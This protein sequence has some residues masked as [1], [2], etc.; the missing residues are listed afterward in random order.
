M[1]K[2]FTQ[3]HSES[4]EVLKKEFGLT[5]VMQAPRLEKVVINSGVGKLKDKKKNEYIAS[6]LAIITGQKAVPRMAKKSIATFKLREGELVGLQV[7]L[8]GPRMHRF[9]D[10]LVNIALPRMKDFRGIP[11]TFDEMGNYTLGIRE[12]NIFP[13]TAEDDLK[14]VFGFAITVVTTSPDAAASKRLL[15]HLNFPF[16]K[17]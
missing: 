2:T 14:D 8:R 12:H 9:L 17:G 13:E 15:E 5:N 11:A 10:K 6:R 1:K 7:T 16:K 4:F 3:L